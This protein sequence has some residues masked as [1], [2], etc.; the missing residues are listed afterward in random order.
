MRSLIM[1][2]L[3]AACWSTPP[4]TPSQVL[5][6]GKPVAVPF[7]DAVITGRVLLD[8]TLVPEIAIGWL[9]PSMRPA[10]QGAATN[11]AKGRFNLHV[12][13][14]KWTLL[15]AGPGF[16][17][18]E[19]PDRVLSAGSVTDLGDITPRRGFTISGSVTD[20]NGQP[21]ADAE[22]AVRNSLRPS[23]EDPLIARLHG[24]FVTSSDKRGR[25]RLDGVTHLQL[26]TRASLSARRPNIDAILPYS[27]AAGNL[28]QNIVLQPTGSI[29]G[30]VSGNAGSLFVYSVTPHS[31]VFGD[32]RDGMFEVHDLPAGTYTVRLRLLGSKQ[33]TVVANQASPVQFP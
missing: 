26:H 9:T 28:T 6:P 10:I 31:L 8:G 14:G 2:W 33:V 27:I 13:P 32:V 16:A 3:V 18:T 4:P 22:V 1:I 19:L 5:V 17:R 21:V 29:V 11:Q 15:I 30:T 12:P 7:T 20:A 23:A 25:Y 24:D